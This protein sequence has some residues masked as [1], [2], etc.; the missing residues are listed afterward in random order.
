MRDHRGVE[1]RARAQQLEEG[2][3]ALHAALD[4]DVGVVGD[5]PGRPAEL[6]HDV[7]AGVDA[8]AALD[9]AEIGAVADVDAGRADVHA[10]Q[11]V[12]AVAGRLAVGAQLLGL[13]D[14]AARLAAVVAVGDVE[15]VF[16]GERRLDAR[17]RAHIEA[18]LLAHM[19]GERVG[20]EGEDA[21]P[22]IGD[23]RRLEGGEILHQRRRVGEI[24]H[25]GAAGP[26]GD[27]QPD[28]ML[29]AL[30]RPGRGG[31]LAGVALHVLAAVAFDQALD[32]EEQVGPHR[33]RAEI[34]A[35]DAAGHGVHQEQRRSP[36]GSTGR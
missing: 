35:P 7:V 8:Q 33:L 32:R 1:Q 22:G 2:L 27:H 11:A 9:A 36:R 29:D 26:P 34:A 6:L 23:E 13:L 14:R 10:L 24:E 31:P 18:D 15:R 4:V 5:Q 17:P 20:G 16:V 19:A 12:D 28:E 21:D 3:L 30:A 25:P